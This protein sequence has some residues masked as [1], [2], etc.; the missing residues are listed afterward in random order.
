MR[1]LVVAVL[2]VH[3]VIHLM[4]FAKA[5][6]YAALP[7]L[8]QLISRGVGGLWLLAATLVIAVAAALAAGWRQTWIVG[9]LALAASQA[10]ITLSWRDA[11]AGTLANVLLLLVVATGWFTAGPRSF[12]AQFDRDVASAVARLGEA[13]L[14]TDADL[15]PLPAPVARYLRLTGV[16]G[17]PRVQNYRLRFSGR[18]RGAPDSRWMPFVAEQRSFTDQPTRLFLMHARMFGL[19]VEVLHRSIDGHATMQVKLFGAIPIADAR[20][21]VMDRSEAVTMFNDMCLLM[22]PTLIDPAITWEQL[23]AHSVR[24][25]F[26]NRD[27]AITA[28][29]VFG[30]D[31]RL[32]NFVSE[33]RSRSSADGKTFTRLRF[34][35]PVRSYRAFGPLT[36]TALG[37]GRWHLPEG[38][39]V[40]GE[41]HLLDAAVNER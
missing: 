24:A 9:A 25:G 30:E 8:T 4:G 26:R 17:Q 3:G 14:I 39:F 38:E 18:I 20:G 13:R 6:G 21:E 32:T 1:W 28:T 15:A 41:F 7:Q 12:Q 19:P 2:T 37:E 33:D 11:W 34:S 5:F 10:V 23:D 22:P 35:T 40:Y 27:Q 36:L 29:L 31:G 16:V